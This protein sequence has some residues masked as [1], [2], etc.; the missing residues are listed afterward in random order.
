METIALQSLASCGS[1]PGSCVRP[2]ALG[3]ASF[4]LFCGKAELSVL[5][6]GKGEWHVRLKQPRVH[7]L[8]HPKGA[9]F[10]HSGKA[11]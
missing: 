7:G 2:L 8:S 5:P 11:A 9:R 10:I 1:Q 4:P 3:K 6:C